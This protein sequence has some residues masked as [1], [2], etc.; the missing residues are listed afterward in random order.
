M[1][2]R[3]RPLPLL[4]LLSPIQREIVRLE[5]ERIA[6][7]NARL[8]RQQQRTAESTDTETEYQQVDAS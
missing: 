1:T 2:M 7:E 8:K 5:M 6:T 4:A 3:L